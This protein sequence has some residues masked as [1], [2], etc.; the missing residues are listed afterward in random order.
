LTR[1]ETLRLLRS[2]FA[3][4]RLPE[5]T[6]FYVQIHIGLKERLG[7]GKNGRSED[8]DQEVMFVR[9]SSQPLLQTSEGTPIP[10]MIPRSQ[11]QSEVEYDAKNQELRSKE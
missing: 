3:I 7:D 5:T 1:D 9:L 10:E 8:Q 2:N 4:E 11:D 6:A